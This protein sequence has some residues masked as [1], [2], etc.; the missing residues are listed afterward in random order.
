MRRHA[1]GVRCVATALLAGWCL[2]LAGCAKAMPAQATHRAAAS[3]A[4]VPAAPARAAQD[5]NQQRMAVTV[6]PARSGGT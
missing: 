4:A 3:R 1:R 2:P 6:G 5:P